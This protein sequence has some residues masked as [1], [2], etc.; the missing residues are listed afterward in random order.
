MI[1]AS[2]VEEGVTACVHKSDSLLRL[3]RHREA[4]VP[5]RTADCKSRKP[6][7]NR[8]SIIAMEL[9]RTHHAQL[10]CQISFLETKPRPERASDFGDEALKF[11]WWNAICEKVLGNYQTSLHTSKS[12]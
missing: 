11:H 12:I 7:E 10:V 4:H 2:L 6:R 5:P 8:R 1:H 3:H 9:A